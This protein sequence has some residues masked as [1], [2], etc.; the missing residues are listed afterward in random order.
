M[1]KYNSSN[2]FSKKPNQESKSTGKK[3]MNI[4]GYYFDEE[5]N[6]YF[7]L[8]N[9]HMQ[10]FSEHLN[11]TIK[12]IEKHNVSVSKNSNS[13][14]IKSTTEHITPNSNIQNSQSLNNQVINPKQFSKQF[15]LK[16]YLS[17][18]NICT[19]YKYNLKPLDFYDIF[20]V[21]DLNFD[22][23]S[24]FLDDLY[25]SSLPK[26][27]LVRDSE[28]LN[29]FQEFNYKDILFS[30][31]NS[32][33][34]VYFLNDKKSS[35]KPYLKFNLYF[36]DCFFTN[37]L[38]YF[39]N[40][41]LA[42][43]KQIHNSSFKL[44][45]MNFKVKSFLLEKDFL[46]LIDYDSKI[47]IANLS[48]LYFKQN[49]L[50]TKYKI[51]NCRK[52][53]TVQDKMFF[54]ENE[55]Y[56]SHKKKKESLHTVNELFYKPKIRIY[57]LNRTNCKTEEKSI[58]F[59][60][61]SSIY[62]SFEIS[63][64]NTFY[65]RIYTEKELFKDEYEILEYN[66]IFEEILKSLQYKIFNKE[67]RNEDIYLQM[68]SIRDVIKS[69]ISVEL[70][71]STQKELSTIF[72]LKKIKTES[73]I[74]DF[75]LI[76]KD[77]NYLKKDIALII[78]IKEAFIIE[79]NSKFNEIKRKVILNNVDLIKNNM[80]ISHNKHSV[81]YIQQAILKCEY[82]LTYLVILS[83][84]SIK[85]LN[86]ENMFNYEEEIEVSNYNLKLK[87][88][89][90]HNVVNN[91]SNLS[92]NTKLDIFYFTRNNVLSILSKDSDHKTLDE[93]FE[94]SISNLKGSMKRFELENNKVYIVVIKSSYDN[95]VRVDKLVL[96]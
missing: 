89:Q 12:N 43:L 21:K 59:L 25:Y 74:L 90:Y 45:L 7:P 65:D 40:Y 5:L 82:T 81:L 60:L 42:E 29:I 56:V 28:V 27:S 85:Q 70:S 64:I 68:Q 49:A 14:K 88:N 8:K 18:N 24:K 11:K 61:L 52:P 6:R 66:S 50:E 76:T 93:V 31:L 3:I 37:K 92:Y 83:D 80:S 72:L 62:K 34:S 86:L 36:V 15:L 35:S 67:S 78:S 23:N 87:Q 84:S 13:K 4:P 79:V 96:T 10:T 46:I 53:I 77:K 30:S 69:N 16:D 75:N 48:L 1:N 9:N 57:I 58:T 71:V 38:S 95:K 54:S 39:N 17:K 26:N 32:N 33:K 41:N 94:S 63:V 22:I 44:E 47:F 73:A 91:F 20:Q 2:N 51:I 55:C 19:H